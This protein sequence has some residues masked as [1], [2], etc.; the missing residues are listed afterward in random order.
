LRDTFSY[1]DTIPASDGR[2]D[3]RTDRRTDGRTDAMTANGTSI[4]D[5]NIILPIKSKQKITLC[6]PNQVKIKTV[7]YSKAKYHLHFLDKISQTVFK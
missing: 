7:F 5:T 3:G 1:F 2:T 6:I 4:I